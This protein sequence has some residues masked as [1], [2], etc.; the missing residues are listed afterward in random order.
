MYRN[1]AVHSPAAEKAKVKTELAN[2]GTSEGVRKSWDTRRGQNAELSKEHASHADDFR[3]DAIAAS[4]ADSNEEAGAYTNSANAHAYTNSANA[5][6]QS[7]KA[8]RTGERADHKE[9]AT[10]H[11]KAV[12][13][14]KIAKQPALM[15]LHQKFQAEHYDILGVK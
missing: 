8:Y 10:L 9:A 14:A 7:A 11:G 2:A 4:H 1:Q 15:R 13:S 6:E 12:T 3:M 5:H